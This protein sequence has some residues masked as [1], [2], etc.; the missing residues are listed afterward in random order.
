M[1]TDRHTTQTSTA[2]LRH[3][4][5]VDAPETKSLCCAAVGIIAACATTKVLI[6]HRKLRQAGIPNATLI[7]R[8]R[9]PA[10]P[11]VGYIRSVT[12]NSNQMISKIE[13][14]EAA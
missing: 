5:G 11:D 8:D 3:A 9:P 4:N 13:S 6:P 10:E 2:L 1:K 7:A 12:L 14:W